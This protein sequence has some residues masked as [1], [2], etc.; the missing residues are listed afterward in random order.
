MAFYPF[1]FKKD[2]I[3]KIEWSMKRRYMEYIVSNDKIFSSSVIPGVD[4]ETYDILKSHNLHAPWSLHD[5]YKS[6]MI[7]DFLVRM[8]TFLSYLLKIGIHPTSARLICIFAEKKFRVN[9]ENSRLIGRGWKCNFC[10]I[11]NYY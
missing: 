10:I 3:E 8:N 9:L 5:I 4:Q 2:D 1:L 7:S 11:N 6:I